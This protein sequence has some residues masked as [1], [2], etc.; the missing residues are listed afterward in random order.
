MDRT[1]SYLPV[2]SIAF[3]SFIIIGALAGTVG[4]VVPDQISDYHI[5]KSIIGLLSVAAS[6][7]YFISATSAG[8]LAERLGP[9]R[10]V[11]IG[12]A[13]M[14]LSCLLIGLHLPFLGLVLVTAISNIGAA[15]IDAGFNALVAALPRSTQRLNALHGFFGAGALLGPLVASLLLIQQHWPWQDLYFV[16]GAFSLLLI[17]GCLFLTRSGVAL[18][19]ERTVEHTRDGASMATTLRL[20]AVR[21]GTAFLFLYVGIEISVGIWNYSFS[22]EAR[23]IDPLLAGWIASGYWFGLTA[24]RFLTSPVTKWLRLS[25]IALIYTCLLGVAVGLVLVWFLPGTFTIFGGFILIGLFLGPI[26]PTTI[27]VMPG[28]VSPSLASRAIGILIGASVAGGALFPWAT[29]TLA[30][31]FGIW[32]LLPAI[33]ALIVLM[34]PLW[35]SLTR[36]MKR[37]V[38]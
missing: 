32:T 11:A 10:Y 20:N 29:G 9:A 22:L 28:I 37:T 21:L 17:V 16:W 5:T 38:S 36:Q 24:G 14:A 4:V 6:V 34:F 26:F 1:R 31:T 19:P 15:G 13:I 23:H 27:A 8:A 3:F 35:W 12:A 18:Q 25:T 2:V 7:G 33:L 30:Q